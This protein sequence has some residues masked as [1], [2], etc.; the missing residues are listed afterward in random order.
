MVEEVLGG[1]R[2]AHIDLGATLA[3]G[4]HRQLRVV[5]AEVVGIHD[6]IGVVHRPGNEQTG[7]RVGVAARLDMGGNGTFT[8]GVEFQKLLVL[9]QDQRK[10]FHNIRGEGLVALGVEPKTPVAGR[11]QHEVHGELLIA[12]GSGKSLGKR[13]SSARM[14]AN[15]EN[16]SM[17]P[18]SW[19]PVFAAAFERSRAR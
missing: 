4:N 15:S 12:V 1:F 5:A 8:A 13:W 7:E 10:D 11:T 3:D 2:E 18:A 19:S 17:A 6:A 9:E 14:P 16:T